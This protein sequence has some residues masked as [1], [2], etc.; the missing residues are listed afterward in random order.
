MGT[1]GKL[2]RGR[3]N[4]A[5]PRGFDLGGLSTRHSLSLEPR[6]MPSLSREKDEFGVPSQTLYQTQLGW[7]G[8][9]GKSSL[10]TEAQLGVLPPESVLTPRGSEEGPWPSPDAAVPA[11]YR[12]L[13]AH[14]C[15]QDAELW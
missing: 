5:S 12:N 13:S 6:P 3:D 7:A 15:G 9:R 1:P 11:F 2:D 8:R 10:R 14:L 4:S